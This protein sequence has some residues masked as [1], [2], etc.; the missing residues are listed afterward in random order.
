MCKPRKL[1]VQEGLWWL[2]LRRARVDALRKLLLLLALGA[3][4]AGLEACAHTRLSLLHVHQH[5]CFACCTGLKSCQAS[6][7]S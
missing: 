1:Q 2:P 3:A 7:D 4:L 5:H 6:P